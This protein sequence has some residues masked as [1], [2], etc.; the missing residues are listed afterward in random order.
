MLTKGAGAPAGNGRSAA[1]WRRLRARTTRRIRRPAPAGSRRSSPVPAAAR[2]AARCRAAAGNRQGRCG[3]QNGEGKHR[4]QAERK[5]NST[6]QPHRRKSD[7]PGQDRQQAQGRRDQRLARPERIRLQ[8]A[9]EGE[10]GLPR[11]RPAAPSEHRLRPRWRA[12][13]ADQPPPAG[14]NRHPVGRPVRERHA[15]SGPARPASPLPP[16]RRSP[17]L[18]QPISPI[19]TGLPGNR[20]RNSRR[21]CS[22]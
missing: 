19:T 20:W 2:P 14:S 5:G 21:R 3:E 1:W 18:G 15:R 10:L 16:P 8:R 9:G 4:L 17:W 12:S 11:R 13:T 22:A 7:Q 6:G